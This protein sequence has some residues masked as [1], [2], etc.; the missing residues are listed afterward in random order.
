MDI[1]I[2]PRMKKDEKPSPLSI[3]IYC[4]DIG[5]EFEIEKLPC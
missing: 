3:R 4:Q 2:F 5:R 1:E